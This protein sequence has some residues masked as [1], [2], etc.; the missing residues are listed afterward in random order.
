MK[1]QIKKVTE[2]TKKK[3]EANAKKIVLQELFNDLYDDRMAV[4]RLNF[5]RGI[6]FGLGGVIGGTVVIALIIYT[7]TLLSGIIPALGDFFDWISRL[8]ERPDGA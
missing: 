8:L 7:L 3:Q 4:Y 1:K 2:S 5:F 6:F